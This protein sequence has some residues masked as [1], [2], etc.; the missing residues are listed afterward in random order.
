MA[1]KTER[2]R[3]MAHDVVIMGIKIGTCQSWIVED[4]GDDDFYLQ[5][6]RFKPEGVLI[7]EADVISFHFLTGKYKVWR[8]DGTVLVEGPIFSAYKIC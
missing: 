8:E 7:P 3:V 1:P 2:N 5:V 4:S 6:E